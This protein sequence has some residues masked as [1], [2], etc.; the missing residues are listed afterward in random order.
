MF[1]PFSRASLHMSGTS[2]C[3]QRRQLDALQRSERN[4]PMFNIS[5]VATSSLLVLFT[6]T[7]TPAAYARGDGHSSSNG[8]ANFS[9]PVHSDA[10]VFGN[11][12]LSSGATAHPAFV[13]DPIVRDHRG[14]ED[15]IGNT[16]GA[17]CNG[18]C[19]GEGGLHGDAQ[20]SP[21]QP[22]PRDGVVHDHRTG[23]P[24]RDHRN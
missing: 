17:P 2:L 15:E 16:Y 18:G 9:A 19:V 21:Q 22:N 6:A 14:S 10:Q 8:S 20:P 1:N 12:T 11:K 23:G 4:L 3:L 7:L 5:R 13:G 24:V